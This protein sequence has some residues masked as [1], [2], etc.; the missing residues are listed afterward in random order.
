MIHVRS[1]TVAETDTRL[2]QVLAAASVEA[3]P[4]PYAYREIDGPIT[5]GQTGE[6]LAIVWDGEQVSAL[7]QAD[8]TDRAEI[9]GVSK[10]SFPRR[11][12]NSGFVG[13]LATQLKS[14]LGTGV[15]VVCGYNSERG[16]IFDYWGF[17]WHLRGEVAATI[18]GLKR[19]L[20]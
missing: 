7:M 14:T 16:G 17:P 8:H 20:S 11:I 4:T 3:L 18:N 6:V 19:P 2:R 10:I 15:F 1:E 9:L 13:W 12:D 5:A